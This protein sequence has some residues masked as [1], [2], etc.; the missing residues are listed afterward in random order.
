MTTMTSLQPSSSNEAAKV[1][2]ITAERESNTDDSGNDYKNSRTRW[3]KIQGI[4]W[5]GGDRTLEERKLVQRLDIY[6]M[7]WATFGYFI[8]LLDSGNI[9]ESI[10]W[11]PFEILKPNR[12]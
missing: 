12:A 6:V 2:S 1:Y 4:I 10:L 5:D 7:S 9:S 8:R 3:E 11:R